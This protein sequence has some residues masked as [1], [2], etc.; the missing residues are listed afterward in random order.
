M[1]LRQK[2]HMQME[3]SKL[4]QPNK[5]QMSKSEVKKMFTG[6]FDSDGIIQ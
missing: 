2:W 1:A 6:F 3:N 5:A 4:T